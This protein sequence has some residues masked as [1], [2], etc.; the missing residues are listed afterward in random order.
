M[1]ISRRWVIYQS[2]FSSSRLQFHG[3]RFPSSANTDHPFPKRG[4]TNVNTPHAAGKEA[5]NK[6]KAGALPAPKQMARER[7]MMIGRL[8]HDDSFSL[9]NL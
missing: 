3:G 8:R 7:S 6:S 5:K 9:D 4:C 2:S 1:V